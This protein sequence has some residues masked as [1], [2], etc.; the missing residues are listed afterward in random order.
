MKQLHS[1][2]LFMSESGSGKGA[3]VLFFSSFHNRPLFL[4]PLFPLPSSVPLKTKPP[5]RAIQALRG[6]AHVRGYFARAKWR[7]DWIDGNPGTMNLS[8]LEETKEK[9]EPN[10]CERKKKRGTSH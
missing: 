1:V 6:G 3:T 10:L 2:Q 7:V 8:I 9:L 5:R 4:F